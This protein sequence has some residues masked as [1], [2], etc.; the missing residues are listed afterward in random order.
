MAASYGQRTLALGGPPMIVENA[1]SWL[2]FADLVFVDPPGTGYSK[3]SGDSEDLRKQFFSVQG[4]AD[5]L[6][7]VFASG[8]PHTDALPRP[9]ISSVRAMGVFA[10]SNLCAR[11]ESAK[12]WG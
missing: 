3:I 6:A 4:D 10:P 5:A 12:A 7:V 8:W 11:C 2:T 1:E 9:N